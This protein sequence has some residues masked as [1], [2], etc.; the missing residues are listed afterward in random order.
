M[1]AES[2]HI[3]GLWAKVI[4]QDRKGHCEEK[5]F[6]LCLLFLSIKDNAYRGILA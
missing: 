3:G 2:D 6:S 1:I 4:E 5:V